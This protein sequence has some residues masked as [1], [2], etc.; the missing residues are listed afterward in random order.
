[1]LGA[2]SGF[3]I[4]IARELPEYE[5]L[6]DAHFVLMDTDRKR[7]DKAEAEVRKVLSEA[8]PGI[9]VDTTTDLE[10]ALDGCDYVIASCEMNR[11]LFWIK[12]KGEFDSYADFIATSVREHDWCRKQLT[13]IAR[14]PARQRS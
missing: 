13:R 3:V 9:L 4:N 8:A 11:Y 2:G 12:D 7:L 5:S 6:Q 14:T 1:M 10:P